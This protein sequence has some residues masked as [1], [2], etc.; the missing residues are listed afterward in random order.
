MFGN[1]AGVE[2]EI[3][4]LNLDARARADEHFCDLVP[5]KAVGVVNEDAISGQDNLPNSS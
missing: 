2:V 3:G 4:S 5:A 1:E